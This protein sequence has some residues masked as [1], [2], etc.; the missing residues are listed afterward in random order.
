[1]FFWFQI[2]GLHYDGQR[3][4]YLKYN[5]QTGEYDFYSQVMPEEQLEEK[6]PKVRQKVGSAG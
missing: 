3:G 5:Q 4:C 1:M 6:K 2:Y